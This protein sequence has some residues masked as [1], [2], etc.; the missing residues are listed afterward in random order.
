MKKTRTNRGDGLVTFLAHHETIRDLLN[1]GYTIKRIHR[2]LQLGDLSYGQF[3][4][5]VRQYFSTIDTPVIP[6]ERP[7]KIVP[8]KSTP[9]EPPTEKP[10]FHFNIDPNRKFE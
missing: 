3:G 1:A 6:I 5:Y 2:E 7:Q 10:V 4:R 9:P 8:K